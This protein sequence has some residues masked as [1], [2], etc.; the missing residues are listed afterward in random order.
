MFRCMLSQ[1]RN[2]APGARPDDLRHP[3][4]RTFLGRT[5]QTGITF[6]DRQIPACRD[7]ALSLLYASRDVVN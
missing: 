6:A 1:P 7:R 5:S 4:L 3:L 2:D